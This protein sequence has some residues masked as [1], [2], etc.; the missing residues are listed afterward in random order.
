MPAFGRRA[1]VRL[2]RGAAF[3]ASEEIPGSGGTF[4]P[5][6]LNFANTFLIDVPGVAVKIAL[7]LHREFVDAQV[8]RQKLQKNAEVG[9]KLTDLRNG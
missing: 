7:L 9:G 1:N 6:S 3:E 2:W 5:A 4:T 8:D